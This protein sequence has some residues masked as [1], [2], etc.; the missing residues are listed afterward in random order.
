M[1]KAEDGDDLI[2]RGYDAFNEAG[3]VVLEL[4]E[5]IREVWL[6]DLMEQETKRLP[7]DK[8]RVTIAVSNFEII[9]LRCKRQGR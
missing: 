2:L 6:C 9:T 5:R 7:M 8:N 1:K 3:T 4:D